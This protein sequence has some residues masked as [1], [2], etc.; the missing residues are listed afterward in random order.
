LWTFRC[1]AAGAGWRPPASRPFLVSNRTLLGS[2]FKFNR[3]DFEHLTAEG[4][5][6]SGTVVSKMR[7]VDETKMMLL[8]RGFHWIGEVGMNR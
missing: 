3:P 5:F 2:I 4:T 8:S 7:R 6:N 1:G